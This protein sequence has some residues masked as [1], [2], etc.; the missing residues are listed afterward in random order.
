M[1]HVNSAG[2]SYSPPHN[3]SPKGVTSSSGVNGY[4][5]VSHASPLHACACVCVSLTTTG[6][7]AMGLSEIFT[8][9]DTVSRNISYSTRTFYA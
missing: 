2:G 7:V 6:L 9:T 8:C 4:N 3:L 5:S 1:D